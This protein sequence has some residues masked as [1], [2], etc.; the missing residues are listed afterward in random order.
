MLTEMCRHIE[1][2]RNDGST[3]DFILVTGDIAFSGQEKN[4]LS[5]NGSSMNW[6]L[7][8]ECLET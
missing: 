1:Q 8:R 7:S 6:R 4:T 5:R 3:F 2:Q